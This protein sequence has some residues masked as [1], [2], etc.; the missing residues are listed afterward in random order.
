M[1]S[2]ALTLVGFLVILFTVDIICSLT[3]LSV[4]DNELNDTISYAAE[5]TIDSLD[6]EF[7]NGNNV[8]PNENYCKYYHYD[9]AIKDAID[10]V[11]A[12]EIVSDE[13]KSYMESKNYMSVSQILGDK[14]LNDVYSGFNVDFANI[15]LEKVFLYIL[16]DGK[17]SNAVY[18]VSFYCVDAV[19]G[20][21]DV[22][23]TQKS[24]YNAI[25]LCETTARRTIIKESYIK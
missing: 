2:V 3:T 14:R 12:N 22:E 13:F 23:V 25:K 11:Y 9:L 24:K 15:V 4:K 17:D 21:L 7:I 18:D 10:E 5:M 6:N 20:I 16:Y 19:N 8:V 1:R